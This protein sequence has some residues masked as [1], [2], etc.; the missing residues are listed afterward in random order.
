M[1]SILRVPSECWLSP[2][3]AVR[4][5]EIEGLGLFATRDIP[6]G[7][8][9]M[10]LGGQIIDDAT[11]NA[12]T[13][14]YSSLCIGDGAHILIDPAHPVRYGNHSCDPNLWHQDATTVVARRAITKGEELTIDYATHTISQTGS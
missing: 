10:R 5:S 9:V 13:P 14:P 3:A 8:P 12:L 2:A 6:A 1:N 11:L 4:G 7:E